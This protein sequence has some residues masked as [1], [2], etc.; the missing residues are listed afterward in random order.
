MKKQLKEKKKIININIEGGLTPFLNKKNIKMKTKLDFDSWDEEEKESSIKDVEIEKLIN[1]IMVDNQDLLVQYMDM[2]STGSINQQSPWG[3]S[4]SL[5][6]QM[7][8]KNINVDNEWENDDIIKEK[9][10]NEYIDISVQ[11]KEFIH[12]N[13]KENFDKLLSKIRLCSSL[14]SS[15]CRIG[16]AN[17]II[18][19]EKYDNK[20][21]DDVLQSL[22]IENC[23]NYNGED[24]ILYR[25]SD[26]II[27]QGVFLL[28]NKEINN[29]KISRI[30]N[31]ENFFKKIKIVDED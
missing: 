22:N 24:I 5:E 19:P 12:N 9:I 2:V 3:T 25:K 29:Y 8:S 6:V 10:L 23:F 30:G 4:P 15:Q 7:F 17:S 1:K 28:V 14:I 11:E 26:K 16:P 18:I 20:F 21:N 27:S 13:K 31:V